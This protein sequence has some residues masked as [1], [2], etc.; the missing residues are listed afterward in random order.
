MRPIC[1]RLYS[2]A[3]SSSL[4]EGA[5]VEEAEAEAVWKNQV[6]NEKRKLVAAVSV[7]RCATINNKR[8]ICKFSQLIQL[9]IHPNK[10]CLLP[11]CFVFAS[12][13]QQQQQPRYK[14]SKTEKSQLCRRQYGK[15]VEC[16]ADHC[17]S[18][19]FVVPTGR[20]WTHPDRTAHPSLAGG[21]FQHGIP[22]FPP[23]WPL[24]G[25]CPKPTIGHCPRCR[26]GRL[27][28]LLQIQRQANWQRGQ[29]PCAEK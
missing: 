21:L 27:V 26:I 17:S 8:V 16:Y 4:I 25:L 10:L 15:L 9:G 3:S 13:Q 28:V 2:N 12:V 11:C 14:K 23:A 5:V 29:C 18:D 7:G 19:R 20:H 24:V 22:D 1:S 6:I